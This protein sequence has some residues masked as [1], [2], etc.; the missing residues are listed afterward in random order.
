VSPGPE[1][2]TRRTL[3]RR[4]RGGDLEPCAAMNADPEVMEHF[5]APLSTWE[6][7]AFIERMELSFEE[8]GYGLWAVEVPGGAALIGCVG[9][10]A[11]ERDLPFAPA[12]EVGWR[13]ARAHWRKGLAGEAASAAI[14][15][16]FDE[17]RLSELVAYTA[18][19]NGRS[20]RLMER[21]DMRRDPAEDFAHPRLP[22]SHPLATHVVYRLGERP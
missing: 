10:L 1:L 16:A 4:W 12:V 11:V 8:R 18:A 13:L 20:R 2:R 6:T 3:L 15:F 14:A 19:R 21:L 9:L 7:A 17:L 5:P 22:A